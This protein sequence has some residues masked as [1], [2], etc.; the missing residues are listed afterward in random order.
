MARIRLSGGIVP[1]ADQRVWLAGDPGNEVDDSRLFPGAPVVVG[2]DGAGPAD[3]ERARGEACRLVAGGGPLVAAAGVDVGGGFRSSRLEG[4]GE[5]RRNAVLAAVELLGPEGIARI[6]TRDAVLVALF[7]TRAT[8]RVGAAALDVLAGP[9]RSAL[10]LAV[11][12]SDVLG[13]EQ[14]EQVLRLT[15]PDGVD[16]LPL[17]TTA[18]LS[19]HLTTLLAPYPARR[20]LVV[21]RSLWDE[22]VAWHGSSA[23]RAGDRRRRFSPTRRDAL[24][25]RV[26]R[27]DDRWWR[28]WTVSQLGADPNDARML[29]WTPTPY[30]WREALNR[31]FRECVAATVLVRT[32][33]AAEER[34]VG[35]AVL[36]HLDQLAY[37]ATAHV[38]DLGDRVECLH[39]AAAPVDVAA[40]RAWNLASAVVLASEPSDLLPADTGARLQAQLRHACEL[41]HAVL[42]STVDLARAVDAVQ[43]APDERRV[44]PEWR[45]LAG[46]RAERDPRDWRGGLGSEA[47]LGERLAGHDGDAADVERVED[48][49]WLAD[50][51]DAVAAWVGRDLAHMDVGGFT[52]A[53]VDPEPPEDDFGVPSLDSV[54]LAV[55]GA[56][57]LAAL[58]AVAGP[59]PASWPALVADLVADAE[60]LGLHE[61]LAVPGD[62][63]AW[64][65][66]R[67]PGTDLVVEVARTAKQL[68]EWGNYMGNCI[69]SY[70]EDANRTFALVALR[71]AS[72]RLVA[73]ISVRRRSERWCVQEALARFNE[74]LPA[75]LEVLIVQWSHGLRTP[76]IAGD[77]PRVPAP[78]AGPRPGRGHR[79]RRAPGREALLRA[80]AALGEAVGE[81]EARPD[82]GWTRDVVRPIAVDLG[83]AGEG[84]DWLGPFVA[85][86]RVRRPGA[87]ADALGRA[88]DAGLPLAELWEATARRPLAEAVDRLGEHT[89]DLHRLADPTIPVSLRLALRDPRVS[90]AR[91]V[92]LAARRIR[93]ALFDLLTSGD[94]RLDRAVAIRPHTDFVGTAVLALAASG[95]ARAGHRRVPAS[96]TGP[97]GFPAFWNRARTVTREVARL[98]PRG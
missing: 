60:R 51:A 57:Q 13:P 85:V 33:L 22:V 61:K 93:A 67:L 34:P 41:A 15:A 53:D 2:P 46:Y 95:A 25:A 27:G 3:V 65:G 66:R 74:Q 63:A 73:N 28:H 30:V 35:D 98:V 80:S 4:G 23:A 92:D 40:R 50:L 71:D 58:G 49:L 64:D 45:R 86:A 69:A 1:A 94:P 91:A 31:A 19:D 14:L 59:R 62:V 20:R 39:R 5:V 32:A 42:L 26:R 68:T 10:R 12:G 7:G 21:V 75:E 36:A 78:P 9:S 6:G 96:W 82:L 8:K 44:T 18:Q 52:V 81:L 90:G 79:R 76:R 29:A 56:A 83:W 37:A 11:A 54:P 77:R 88:L 17:G 55:A 24:L 84:G 70:A 89:P 43:L 38:A 72:G 97:Q 87:L 16:L 47:T 48:G